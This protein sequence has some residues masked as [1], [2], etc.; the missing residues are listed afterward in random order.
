MGRFSFGYPAYNSAGE[1]WGV[2]DDAPRRPIRT[3]A[4]VGAGRDRPGKNGATTTVGFH[5]RPGSRTNCFHHD[6]RGCDV[7]DADTGEVADNDF[8][9]RYAAGGL[10]AGNLPELG[11]AGLLQ[12]ACL[13]CV[14]DFAKAPALGKAV[15]DDAI[16]ERQ[17]IDFQLAFVGAVGADSDDQGPRL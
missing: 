10:A 16:G 2:K 11:D 5:L 15:C 13:E 14:V 12:Y 17:D 3:L 7:L 1:W 9:I 8:R 6:R 4:L